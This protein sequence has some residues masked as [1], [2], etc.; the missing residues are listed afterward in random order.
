MPDTL[1]VRLYNV[2]FGDALLVTVPDRD[3]QTGVT[4]TRR[5]LVDVGNAPRVAGSGEG[6]DDVVF[7]PVL[8]DILGVLDGQPIDLYVMTHEHLDHAQ[9]L[10]YAATKLPQ[11]DLAN[12]FAASHVW[13]TASAHPQYYDTH[14][15][16]RK[17]KLDH[18]AMYARL[19]AYLPLHP[20]VASRGMLEILANNDPTKTGQCVDFLRTLSPQR[21]AYVSRGMDLAGTHPFRE[22]ALSVWAPEEDTSEYYGTFE[23]LD[24]GAVPLPAAAEPG[25]PSAR[26]APALANPPAGVDVGAFLRLQEARRGGI[27]DNLLAI[28]RAANNTSI[29]F[30]LEWRGWRLLFAGDAEIRSWKTMAREQV[31]RPVHFLKVSHHGS[32]NGTPTDEIFDAIFPAAAPDG[33]PRSAAISTWEDTYPGIPHASTNSRL[34]SRAAL[35]S[36]LDDPD[37][38]FVEL[39]FPG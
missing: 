18:D 25:G 33:R 36:I 30:A 28:D 14:P 29:V 1:T 3:P 15:E 12:R 10:F 32:H 8:S 17:K 39:A 35:H 23:P 5:I 31:L 20:A 34:E 38:L 6:G 21:T 16:A 37:K 19:A 9:G 11:L 4:A 26:R 7:E 27:A 24:A 13:L 2:R 22:A